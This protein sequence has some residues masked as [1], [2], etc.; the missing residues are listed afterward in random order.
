MNIQ[1]FFELAKAKGIEESQ[2]QIGTSKSISIKLFHH[3]ID[4]YTI[5]ESRSVKACGIYN[6]K[7]GSATTQKVGP[8]AFEFLVDQIILA[9]SYSEKPNEIGIFKGSE[10]YHKRDL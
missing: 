1:K 3:E 6:G 2:I 5:S 9:A 10:R 7:F 8:D 4:K